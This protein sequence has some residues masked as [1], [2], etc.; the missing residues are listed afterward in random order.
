[1]ATS[2][3]ADRFVNRFLSLSDAAGMPVGD[4]LRERESPEWVIAERAIMAASVSRTRKLERADYARQAKAAPWC[5][6]G[7]Q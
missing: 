7:G 1:M 2:V 5:H 3:E 4:G 6:A